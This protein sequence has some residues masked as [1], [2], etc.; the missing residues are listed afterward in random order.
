[1]RSYL[2]PLAVLAGLVTA[3]PAHAD[4]YWHRGRGHDHGWHHGWGHDHGWYRD[5]GYGYV[6]VLPP[7]V[8]Y[9]PPY[10]RYQFYDYQP[11]Y[12]GGWRGGEDD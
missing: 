6:Y 1:M 10:Y 8:Y 11:P 4:D 12:Y 5:R 2:A 9:Q 3:V 7:P